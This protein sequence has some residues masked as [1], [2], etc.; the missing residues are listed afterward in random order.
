M[1]TFTTTTTDGRTI[2]VEIVQAA[3]YGYAVNFHQ[4]NECVGKLYFDDEGYRVTAGELE[5]NLQDGEKK[6]GTFAEK[7]EAFAAVISNLAEYLEN[8]EQDGSLRD[9]ADADGLLMDELDA[10][11]YAE[12]YGE[13]ARRD[14]LRRAAYDL[15]IQDRRAHE[16]MLPT[17]A[18]RAADLIRD[19]MG[20]TLLEQVKQDLADELGT[21]GWTATDYTRT[22][23]R[24]PDR[25]H[26]AI[27][28]GK[29][30]ISVYLEDDEQFTVRTAGATGARL[31]RII[32]A[33]YTN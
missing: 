22:A 15:G 23:Y 9:P 14:I 17:I 4:L 31:A 28:F 10:E 8:N 6:L 12:H 18:R 25:R 2:E 11:L 30:A 13:A 1:Q 32:T 29:G 24:S 19:E 21:A 5:I 20:P 27:N 16:D 33:Y 26:L 7:W 3:P